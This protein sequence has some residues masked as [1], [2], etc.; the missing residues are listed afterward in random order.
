MGQ[1]IQSYLFLVIFIFIAVTIWERIDLNPIALNLLHHL[2]HNK[3]PCVVTKLNS[4]I[5]QYAQEIWYITFLL[6][7]SASKP[8]S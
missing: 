5:S 3:S 7:S 8:P 2:Q 4:K 1:L 6:F